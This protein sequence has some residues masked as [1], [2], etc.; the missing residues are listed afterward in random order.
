MNCDVCGRPIQAGDHAF[1]LLAVAEQGEPG[2]AEVEERTHCC[3][4][5][6]V[7]TSFLY[8]GAVEVGGGV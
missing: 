6:C 5:L 1:W 2:K 3:S 7:A 4:A 8:G